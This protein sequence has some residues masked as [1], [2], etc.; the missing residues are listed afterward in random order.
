MQALILLGLIVLNGLFAMAEIALV[1][2]RKARLQ[3]YLDEGDSAAAAA[4]ALGQQPTRFLST[5]QIGITSIGVLNGVLGEAALAQPLAQWLVQG[6]L[7]SATARTVA[8]ALVVVTITYLSI[9]I[10]EL[11]PKRLGQSNPEA[12]ARL[13]ARPIH[14]LAQFTRPFVFLLTLSTQGVLRLL[15]VREM[16]EQAVTEDEIHAVLAE[17][18]DSGAIE[19]QEHRM[20][21]NLF[22]LDDRQ[23][24]S[25]MVPRSDVVCLDINDSVE[26]HLALIARHG[27]T[28]FPVID[29]SLEKVLGV[30]NTRQWLL[31]LIQNQHSLLQARALWEPPVYIPETITGLE[32]LENFKAHGARLSFVIDEYGEV[33]G[34]VDLRDLIEA[35]TGEFVPENPADAWAVQRSDGSWLLDGHIP[36]FELKDRLGLKKLP[37]EDKGRYQTLSGMLMLLTGRLPTETDKIVWQGWEFE[38]VDMDGK[39][40]D[41]VQAVQLPLPVEE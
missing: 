38:V 26:A 34:V 7:S 31:Q 36:I 40:I 30:L 24:S 39:I 9:V 15:G 33:L 22:R 32:L 6:G 13:V 20:V 29:G 10:G 16:A 23:I 18:T 27:H 41:K 21:R 19:V 35:I 12:I 37:E 28:R 8:T 2:A 17:G 5:I 3:K 25:L 4:I 14:W 11:V 1:T